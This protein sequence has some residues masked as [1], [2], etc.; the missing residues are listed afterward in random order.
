MKATIKTIHFIGIGG[1]GMSALARYFLAQ[2]LPVSGSD[3][4]QSPITRALKKEGANVKIGHKKTNI[5]PEIGLVI[6]NRAI[7]ARNP[8][9]LEAKRLKIPVLPYAQVLG[10]IVKSHETIAITGSHGKTTTTALAGIILMKNNFNPTIFIGSNLTELGGKNIRIGRS[11]HLVLEADDFGGAFLEYA[12]KIAIV[13]NIDREHL[14]FYKTFANLKKS[15]LQFLANVVG[16]GAMILNRDDK[17]LYSLRRP[18]AQLAKKNRIRVIWHSRA[19]RSAKDIKKVL[20]IPGEHNVSNALAA[21]ELGRLLKI[22]HR[23]IL[24]ALGSYRGAW[25]RMEY[26]GVIHAGARTIEVFDDYA[27]H[28]TEIKATLAGFR[29]KFPT[30]PLICVFEP[31]QAQ[32][33]QS[34]F[35]DFRDSFSA[36][37]ATVILPLYHVE[38]RDS[39]AQKNSHDLVRAMQK[40]YPKKTILYCA[41]PKRL[42]KILTDLVKP[43]HTPRSPVLVMMGAGNI[44]N[45]SDSLVAQG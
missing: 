23:N 27:H 35:S 6:Y 8:E 29:E 44:V 26:R 39:A 37:D 36:A 31:H 17:N 9:L 40:K 24:R 32:R 7:P 25:R 45:I 4:A 22:P 12:P 19:D 30:S 1:I 33:L 15:F 18:I 2:K 43:I 5:G 13:T 10:E 34:L 14:D 3:A 16:G 42:K 38:G 28:P 20:T 21:Y 41:S 11:P